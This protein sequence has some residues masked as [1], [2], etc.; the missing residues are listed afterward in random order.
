MYLKSIEVQGFKSFANKIN[1]EF[2]NGIT[3]IVGPNGSGKSNVADAVRWVLGE[4]RIK[5]LRGSKMEDVIFSG[6][7]NRRALGFAYVAITLD[8]SE[9][10]LQIDFD[11]VTISRRIFR[12]GESEYMINGAVCRLKDVQELFY[13]TGI[14]KEGYSI[15]GQGQIDKILNGKPEERR[16]LFDE[17][18]G[19]VKFKRRKNIAVKKLDDEKQNLLRVCDV[20]SELEHQ[21]KPLEKQSEVTRK[22]LKLR[23]ELKEYDINMFLLETKDIKTKTSSL[24]EKIGITNNNLNESN[25]KLEETKTE[26]EKL[27]EF[28][29]ELNIK[30]EFI[31]NKITQNQLLKEKF[32][33]EINVLNEQIN[34]AKITDKHINE[35]V[36]ALNKSI[37]ENKDEL[38]EFETQKEEL[39]QNI[40]KALE[41]QE[42]DDKKLAEISKEISALSEEAE[43]YKSKIIN[44]FGE[45]SNLKSKT[46]RYDTMLEHINTRK[47]EL[48]EKIER[49]SGDREKQEQIINEL[50][51]EL[52]TLIIKISDIKNK[53]EQLNEKNILLEK[54][55]NETTSKLREKQN[56]YHKEETRLESL[57]NI[58]ER[59][60]GYGNSI[61]KVMDL[62]ND[63]KGIIGV[64]ADIIKVEKKYEV[65]IETA[66][67]GS[68][69][70]IVT[71]TEKTAKETIEYLKSNKYGRATFLPLSSLGNKTGFNN[72]AALS[73]K[74]VVGLACDLVNISKEYESVVKYL[75]GRIV[76][77]DNID[78]ALALAR[79]YRYS[80]RIVSL[81]GE[82][83]NVGGSLTGGAF[84]NSSNLLGRRREIEDIEKFLKTTSI[85]ITELKNIYK[86]KNAE[87]INIKEDTEKVKV[88]LQENNLLKNTI[89]I[90]LKQAGDKKQEIQD[91]FD[92]INKE[93]EEIE[94]QI[95]E[96]NK[97]NQELVLQLDDL[98]K[99]NKEYESI[100]I[101]LNNKIDL[102]KNSESEQYKIN[103]GRRLEYQSFV[104]QQSYLNNSI[105][106]IKSNLN[107]LNLEL[108]E[109]KTNMDQESAKVN[110]KYEEIET[111]NQSIKKANEEIN[112]LESEIEDMTLSREEQTKDH[113]DFLEKRETLLGFISDLEKE[114]LRLETG[115]EKLD[116][117]YEARVNYLWEEYELTYS[118]AIKYK[119]EKYD[120]I[121][122]MKKVI[123][124]LRSEI[125]SLGDVNPNAIEEYK[126]AMERYSFL[127]NQKDD[128]VKAEE[129]LMKIIKELDDG[130]R[131]QF[132]E[133]FE[134]IKVEFD[135]VFKELF[136]GGK[137]TLELVDAED[138]L[139][140]G[141]RIIAQ[142]TGKK[143]Q[144][145][146]QLSGGE[147]ALTAIALL[148]AIQNMKP[149]PFC[150]LDE[151][152]AALDDPNVDRFADYL[153]K[154]KKNTQFIV[155]T[156][157]KGTMEGA[158]RLYGITMQEKGVSTLVSVNLLE[159][160]IKEEVVG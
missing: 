79:K 110:D 59:Y 100:V 32:E 12:S 46:Q 84:K 8:N 106:K 28:L 45:K 19:I 60:E 112:Q 70:N 42:E 151:I 36:E 74:G 132:D 92:S 5:Q 121:S 103:E 133:K 54:D 68:I 44:L 38:A 144:N 61:K 135:R 145:M 114:L 78:N 63:K 33:G 52:E 116:E 24:N 65:A 81:E 129:T 39:S 14:G 95:V 120:N 11:E 83:L 6:T 155:I 80:L 160:H 18:A 156:H 51:L 123:D 49:F 104:Q 50:S 67:G 56:K 142:P 22:Y 122:S 149:S 40:L 147:K 9:H 119:D 148:F 16:E 158:D 143:L 73:E 94:F 37:N 127:K 2:H 1:F 146:M 98:E 35:K 86:N 53:L 3:A 136:G 134:I 157:R 4:Q 57:K 75:L 107:K 72:E 109:V 131:K 47:E 96:I 152:E 21:I 7:E 117:N 31:K 113:K 99:S 23:D 102:H 87:L 93:N 66:L 20:I 101:E 29:E 30:I 58:T 108:I 55:I 128:L 138:V 41:V 69:Q 82:L 48:K 43:N 125:R 13:D 85:E 91:S 150:V 17:A 15:I 140:A 77:T 10:S 27:G 139:E 25:L 71:D 124:S 126:N 105:N 130:M 153:N 64:V 154:L 159:N 137:G 97:S 62:K 118:S 89:E 76:V 26:Y 111:L 88:T 34:T 90:N 115:K 141:I